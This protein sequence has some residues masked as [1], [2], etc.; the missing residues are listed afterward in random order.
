VLNVVL[1]AVGATDEAGFVVVGFGIAAD[2]AVEVKRR[3]VR[4]VLVRIS[5]E[6]LGK[7]V[8]PMLLGKEVAFAR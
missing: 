2:R 5:L 1:G 6:F 4:R 7:M 8:D 3:V